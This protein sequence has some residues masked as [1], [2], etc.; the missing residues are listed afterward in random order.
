MAPRPVCPACRHPGP[1][2]ALRAV[3]EALEC[4]RCGETYPVVVAPVVAHPLAPFLRDLAP[5]VPGVDEASTRRLVPWLA[6]DDALARRMQRVS[7]AARAHWGDRLDPPQ[8]AAW[9]ALRPWLARLPRGDVAELG[10]GAG[11]VAVE[12]AADRSVIALDTD[13]AVLAAGI[14]VRDTGAFETSLRAIGATYEPARIRAPDLL[15]RDVTFLLADALDP[16]LA[17]GAF[18]AVVALNL[19]DNVRAPAVL[20]GQMDALLK[21]GGVAL[22]STPYGWDSAITDDGERIGGAAGRRFGGDPVQ[23]LHALLGG[24]PLARPG[25][26][27]VPAAP[28]RWRIEDEDLHVPWTLVRDARCRFAYDLHVVLARK[29]G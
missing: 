23:E 11:R 13:P 12:L 17:A 25:A 3:A 9:A 6:D 18:D 28:W 16:P 22:L 8:E 1:H 7:V 5:A 29:I 19:L 15:G 20:L 4:P 14:S 2:A 27:G 21:P 10:C 26:D 24:E